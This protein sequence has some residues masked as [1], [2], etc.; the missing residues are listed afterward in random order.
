[1]KIYNLFQTDVWKSHSSR[2]F[3]GSFASFELAN[4]HAKSNSLYSDDSEVV[5][6]EAILNDFCEQ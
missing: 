1:M 3:F 5:I 2:V 6:I 4:K